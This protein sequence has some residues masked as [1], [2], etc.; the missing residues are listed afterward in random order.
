VDPRL[1]NDHVD[2]G[3]DHRLIA[4]ELAPELGHRQVD[5]FTALGR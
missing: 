3:V 2:A 4:A 5:R 1:G